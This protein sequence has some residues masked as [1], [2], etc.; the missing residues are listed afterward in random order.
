MRK[1]VSAILLALPLILWGEKASAAGITLNCPGGLQSQPTI[2]FGG[3]GIPNDRVCFGSFGGVD[4]ALAATERFVNP[5]VGDNGIDTY[6]AVTGD[7]TANGQPA[8]GRWNFDWYV[9]NTTG[10][11]VSVELLWDTDPN[12]GTDTS[13][14]GFIRSI[15]AAGG[16]VQDSWNLGM[17]FIDTGIATLGY[18]PAAGLFS[19]Y[20]DGNYSFRLS[21][22]SDTQSAGGIG[23]Q[24]NVGDPRP[25]PEPASFLLMGGGLLAGIRR[26]RRRRLRS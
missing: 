16:L 13:Q 20:V 26:F 2:T 7:D 5:P 25:V 10:S 12:F 6:T 9:R 11:A 22:L 24:V 19:P 3:S 21:I 8:Y 23:M 18:S 14:M 17:G 15:V 4:L 1:I